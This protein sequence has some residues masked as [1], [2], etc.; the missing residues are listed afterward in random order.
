MSLTRRAFLASVRPGTSLS[1]E[2]ALQRLAAAT[3]EPGKPVLVLRP[4]TERPRVCQL[5]WRTRPGRCEHP[6]DNWALT[7]PTKATDVRT[8]GTH[9]WKHQ[10]VVAKIFLKGVA[11]GQVIAHI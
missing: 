5:Y 10:S 2:T 11:A 1:R 4:R 7:I 8:G 6:Q 9:L 3:P